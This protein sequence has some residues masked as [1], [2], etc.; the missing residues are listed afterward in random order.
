VAGYAD[1]MTENIR[2]KRGWIYV[3]GSR[4][5]DGTVKLGTG[6]ELRL[7]PFDA[8]AQRKEIPVPASA[9]WKASVQRLAFWSR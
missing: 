8:L 9:V 3:D 2:V 5:D 1:P 7:S 6:G 4:Q